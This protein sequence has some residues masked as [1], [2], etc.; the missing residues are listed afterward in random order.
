MLPNEKREINATAASLLG[1]L[2]SEPMS[3]YDL[4]AQID[5]S[6]G[7][8]WST[9]QSQIY[10]E[11]GSL[12]ELGYV[13]A[14]EAGLRSRTVYS[15]TS[16]GRAAFAKWIDRMPGDVVIR[17][18]LMLAVFFADKLPPG[19]LAEIL[20]F[21]RANYEELIR[22]YE[23][24]LPAVERDHPYRA[25]T[26]RFGIEEARLVVKWIDTVAARTPGE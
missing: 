10:R 22:E 9:T 7:R 24:R 25:D 26:M 12:A 15:I 4:A 13:E 2:E 20:R 21:H 3:G 16:A 14:G 1:F 18:P 8:F 6:V 5:G 11:L 17:F 23:R 19:R